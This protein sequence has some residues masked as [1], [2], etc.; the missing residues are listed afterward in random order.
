[1]RLQIPVVDRYETRIGSIFN[2]LFKVIAGT[3]KAFASVGE[4]RLVWDFSNNE[5]FHPFFLAAFSIYKDTCRARPDLEGINER[6]SEYFSKACF[7]HPFC[8]TDLS[9]PKEGLSDYI[10]KTFIPISKFCLRYPMLD[11]LESHIQNIIEKQNNL[12]VATKGPLSYILAELIC[13]MKE[14]SQGGYGYI[15]SQYLRRSNELY[16]CLADDGISIYS[17]YVRTEKYLERICCNEAE[18]LKLAVEGYSTKDRPDSENRGFG[19]SSNIDMIVNGLRGSFFILSGSAFFREEFGQKNYVNL[20]K[21]I[22][23]DGTII[24]MRIPLDIPKEFNIIN[25]IA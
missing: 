20:P 8:I 4:E 24:L 12:S 3:E 7:Q 23:W 5:V 14:H 6:L 21:E 19:L 1:M 2:E 25:Y 13:N 22:Y 10:D 11:A 16:L 18:A 9:E 17:S 15:F